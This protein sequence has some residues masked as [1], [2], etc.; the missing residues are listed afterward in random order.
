MYDV[1]VDGEPFLMARRVGPEHGA[2]A[3]SELV[4]RSETS[5]PGTSL[6]ITSVRDRG[7]S[8]QT[9]RTY[10]STAF[11][12]HRATRAGVLR[13][14]REETIRRMLSPFAVDSRE[15]RSHDLSATRHSSKEA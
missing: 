14:R 10:F 9:T 11:T 15:A 13:H 1:A 12:G 4:P 8:R 7:C 6:T 5:A 2:G 3:D